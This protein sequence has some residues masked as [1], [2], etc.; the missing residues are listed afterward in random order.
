VN[1]LLR[2]GRVITETSSDVADV[3]IEDGRIFDVGVKLDA[4][5]G[6]TIVDAEGC[7]VGPSFVD[8][9]THLRE[10]GREEAETIESGARAG[11]LG[12][13]GALVAMPNT[14]PA[15][16]TPALVAF[17]LSRGAV[18]PLD[19]AVAGAITQGR[20]GE[21]LAPIAEMAALGVRLFTDDGSGVQNAAVMRKALTYAKSLGVRL[22]QHCEDDALAADGSMNEGALSSRLGLVGR[23]TLSEELMVLRDIELVRLTGCPLHFMHLSTRRSV[24]LVRAAR[25]EGLPVTCEVTPH[26]LT[27][28]EE[29]LES[30]DPIFKVHPPLRSRRDVE[31]LREALVS[32]DIDAVA[33]DHAPHASELKDL[34]FDE[35][36]AGMLNLEHAGSLAY[37][38][39]GEDASVHTFFSVMS[40]APARIAHLRQVDK[41][42]DHSA[43][44]GGMV[45]GEDA[46]VVV[47]D[48]AACWQVDRFA[49]ASRASNTPY[50]QREM[51]GRVRA[52]VV[53]GALVVNEG[54]LT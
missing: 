21:K 45:A 42:P 31:G 47:F 39:L 25:S 33:T 54:S 3:L 6:V 5:Q 4:P 14:D 9:H 40:R 35:A 53:R 32:G 23:P 50:D 37:E 29:A 44:G 36:P 18:T 17:V 41:H 49:L 46:N 43:H 10:P 24:D 51:R 13:Y 11:A 48:P 19:I 27:L 2:G 28:D 15:L 7:W 38:A 52:L 16:D 8:L 12:G 22:A 34:P 30:Y 26:H 1:V 20:Q